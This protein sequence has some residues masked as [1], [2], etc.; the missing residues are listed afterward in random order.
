MYLDYVHTELFPQFNI[1]G[2]PDKY[3]SSEHKYRSYDVKKISLI[4]KTKKTKL[5]CT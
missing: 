1:L 4:R 2:K 5:E 3:A